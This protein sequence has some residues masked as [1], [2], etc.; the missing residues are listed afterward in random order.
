MCRLALNSGIVSCK[1]ERGVDEGRW[2]RRTDWGEGGRAASLAPNQ[3][4]MSAIL[5]CVPPALGSHCADVRGAE[6][7]GRRTDLLRDRDSP[8]GWEMGLASLWTAAE[9]Q[10]ALLYPDNPRFITSLRPAP[11]LVVPEARDETL[12]ACAGTRSPTLR[13]VLLVPTLAA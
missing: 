2:E 4:N 11:Q 12:T 9:K 8:G 5:G 6:E 7:G 1:R 13:R 10:T 3:I